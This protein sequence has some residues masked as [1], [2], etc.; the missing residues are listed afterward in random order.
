MVPRGGIEH[1][2]A[3]FQSAPFAGSALILLISLERWRCRGA[4]T[5]NAKVR[6]QRFLG[7]AIEI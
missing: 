2:H 1:R 6:P 5:G 4:T 3:D 7:T